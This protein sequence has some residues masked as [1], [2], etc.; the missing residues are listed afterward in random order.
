MKIKNSVRKKLL[1]S[2]L[3]G[4]TLN[5]VVSST[6]F[7]LDNSNVNY[8]TSKYTSISDLLPTATSQ[9]SKNLLQ[10]MLKAREGSK[11]YPV[12]KLHCVFI[13]HGGR[14]YIYNYVA[15]V[16]LVGLWT[17]NINGSYE[18]FYLDKNMYNAVKGWYNVDGHRY[19][20]SLKNWCALKDGFHQVNGTT[21]LFNNAR[22]P[23]ILT[24][25]NSVNG[26]TY[27]TDSVGAV[28]TGWREVNDDRY[29]F[30]PNDGGAAYTGW[31]QDWGL[32]PAD[33]QMYFLN[34]GRMAKGVTYIDGDYYLFKPH[35]S[36]KNFYKAYGYYSNFDGKRYYFSSENKGKAARNQWIQTGRGWMYFHGDGSMAKGVTR[37]G[38]K[39]FVFTQIYSGDYNYYRATGWYTDKSTGYRYYF[40]GYYGEALTGHHVIDGKQYDFNDNGVLVRG[41]Y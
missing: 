25:L 39:T 22:N 27:Y 18:T 2:L 40:G 24:G 17:L 5:G 33:G 19:Y 26:R 1:T 7:A 11:I 37:I 28:V 31:Y 13:K 20:F 12:P 16:F 41:P 32:S 34:D 8:S 38:G 36:G 29:Y 14:L 9:K 23:Y 21:Y 10:Q 6:V 4:I 30:N 15:G 35:G 3:I